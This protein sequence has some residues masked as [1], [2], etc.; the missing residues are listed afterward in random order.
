MISGN[1]GEVETV[2]STV[3]RPYFHA[4]GTSAWTSSCV[5]CNDPATLSTR[6]TVGASTGSVSST[7]SVIFESVCAVTSKRI[8]AGISS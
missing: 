1:Q 6:V 8:F 3:P 4:S 2:T 7:A 5:P